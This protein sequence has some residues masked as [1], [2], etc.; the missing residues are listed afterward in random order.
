MTRKWKPSDELAHV[1]LGTPAQERRRAKGWM[2]EAAM[3]C[4][5]AEYWRERAEKAETRNKK[6]GGGR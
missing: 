5:N 3:Y 4:R 2:D 6:K 1:P